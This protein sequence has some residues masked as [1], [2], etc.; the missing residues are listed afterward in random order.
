MKKGRGRKEREVER[1]AREG[2][3]EG[4]DKGYPDRDFAEVYSLATI[5]RRM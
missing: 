2:R 4:G 3:G 1:I 5:I